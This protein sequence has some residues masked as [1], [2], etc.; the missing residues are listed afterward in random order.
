[1]KLARKRK[2]KSWTIILLLVIFSIVLSKIPPFSTFYIS[3]LIIAVVVGAILGNISH[4]NVLM[5]RRSHVLAVSTKQILRLGIILFGFKLSIADISQ[6]GIVG[7][8]LSFFIVFS[9]F[10]IGYYLG[11]KIGL[12]RKSAALI[13]SGSSICGAA[14]VLAAGSVIKAKSDQIAIAVSTVVVFGTIGMFAYP[15][16]F[17]SQI[18]AF[19][20]LKMGFFTGASLHEVAHVVGAGSA[21]GEV[22]Q[23][24]AVIIKMLRVLMLAPFLIVLSSL[25][26]EA[27]NGKKSLNIRASFPYFAL[28]FLFAVSFN[29]V[30][31]LSDFLLEIIYF[32]DILLLTIAMSALGLTIRK[33]VLKN[34]GKKPFILAFILFI[35]LFLS[36]FCLVKFLI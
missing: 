4:K 20:E 32:I 35:W 13:S 5:L 12:D 17:S 34:A 33:D 28:W 2:I 10:F 24:N 26:L 27:S 16:I 18:L 1:M 8:F 22:A 19:S 36:A 15:L 7:I 25:N 29:S 3:P 6:V 9:T 11:Q 30:G 31:I 21:I 14:A 23:A